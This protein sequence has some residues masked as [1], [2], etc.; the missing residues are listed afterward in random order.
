MANNSYSSE[1]SQSMSVV[2]RSVFL[3]Y[4]STSPSLISHVHICSL[5]CLL[6]QHVVPN[7]RKS[8]ILR[9]QVYSIQDLL[10]HLVSHC[11]GLHIVIQFC[12]SATLELLQTTFSSMERLREISDLQHSF[13]VRHRLCEKCC[14]MSIHED[15]SSSFS[16]CVSD[17]LKCSK[18]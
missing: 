4:S 9:L 6:L 15:H 12:W 17:K 1:L 5:S 16:G 11:V 13:W 3:R 14:P 7:L 2:L 10:R 18:P 8:A